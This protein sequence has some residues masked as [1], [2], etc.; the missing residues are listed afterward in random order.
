MLSF[1][2]VRQEH[3]SELSTLIKKVRRAL[4]EFY[5]P[6]VIMEHG[7]SPTSEGG[8]CIAH[9]HLQVFPG[10]ID[11]TESLSRFR[12]AHISSFWDLAKWASRGKPYLYY[13]NQA[14]DMMVADNIERMERQF[15]RIE[16]SKRI[17]IPDP[18]WDW[19]RYPNRENLVQTIETL[20]GFSG[21]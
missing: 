6:P 14:G 3:R 8:G 16:I 1:G 21:W 9:A 13:E 18:E 5:L 2:A 7:S 15:I 17:G 12:V 10:G 19:R 20:R 11:L 4:S